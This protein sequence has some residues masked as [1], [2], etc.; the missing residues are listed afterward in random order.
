MCAKLL[1][2]EGRAR[3]SRRGARG[4]SPAGAT[5][6]GLVLSHHYLQY[7]TSRRQNLSFKPGLQPTVK[8]HLLRWKNRLGF[9]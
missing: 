2:D 9:I 8:I 1:K 7:R 6:V 3:G 4:R 5:E